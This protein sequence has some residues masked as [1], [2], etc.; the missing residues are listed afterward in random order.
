M[1]KTKK[2]QRRAR[3]DNNNNSN[4]ASARNNRRPRVV[5][6]TNRAANYASTLADPWSV[7]GVRIP[8]APTVPSATIS[9]KVRG[10]GA[11][12][13]LD[14]GCVL[15]NPYRMACNSHTSVQAS[16]AGYA[17]LPGFITGGLGPYTSSSPY[18]NSAFLANTVGGL[19]YRLVSAGLRVTYTGTE[20]ARGGLYLPVCL[21]GSALDNLSLATV[22]GLQNVQP[23]RITESPVSVVWCPCDPS[24]YDY[25][26]SPATDGM[27]CMG[28]II[29]GP[30]GNTFEYEV[31]A[32]FEIF[33][34][35][36]QTST[37]IAPDTDAAA[38][39]VGAVGARN[40]G[41]QNAPMMDHHGVLERAGA[42][43]SDIT[44]VVGDAL[45]TV[46][47]AVLTKKG[48]DVVKAAYAES[49]WLLRTAVKYGKFL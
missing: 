23:M 6:F 2:Q 48:F 43:L 5:N 12:G 30:A 49:P 21:G 36:A 13:T 22:L 3:A 31:V 37:A 9:C 8:L 25:A 15:V 41:G 34:L 19:Q 35:T 45:E 10:A 14:G 27:N 33:G 4:A 47:G 18:A 28:V 20:L 40:T 46:G 44:H 42:V 11:I 29:N 24:D 17:Q 16:S 39:I 7:Q 1:A 32:N 38:A 26:N